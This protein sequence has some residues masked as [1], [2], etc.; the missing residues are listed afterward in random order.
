M[1]ITIEFDTENAAFTGEHGE[2]EVRR[3][4]KDAALWVSENVSA[5]G[6]PAY[7]TGFTGTAKV[8]DHNGNTIGTLR[9][10]E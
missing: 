10:A 6:V 8:R 3:I 5:Y 4:L 1:T 7:G 2:H 9:V